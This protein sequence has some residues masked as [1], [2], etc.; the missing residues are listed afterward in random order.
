MNKKVMV[1]SRFGKTGASVS[2]N[3]AAVK[4][5]VDFESLTAVEGVESI[6]TAIVPVKFGRI[7]I[8]LFPLPERGWTKA[9]FRVN[10]A[11][12]AA[13]LR[14]YLRVQAGVAVQAQV[15]W[16]LA[17][18]PKTTIIDPVTGEE[19]TRMAGLSPDTSY[20]VFVEVAEGRL[21][22]TVDRP[23]HLNA[24][25]AAFVAAFD[26]EGN[27]VVTDDDVRVKKLLAVIE[28]DEAKVKAVKAAIKAKSDT[29]AKA[30][31][32]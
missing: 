29:K 9:A 28:G 21:E 3:K 15:S 20:E 14:K 25:S 31:T 27:V 24:S 30:K 17:T 19:K 11:E 32:K 8:R 7:S 23:G 22:W 26:D 12:E 2:A 16:P 5:F 4:E 18:M 13:G 6:E 1:K 10:G